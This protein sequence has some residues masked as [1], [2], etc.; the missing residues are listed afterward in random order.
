MGDLLSSDYVERHFDEDGRPAQTEVREA[1][2]YFEG[3]FSGTSACPRVL[4]AE[5]LDTLDTPETRNTPDTPETFSTLDT[6]DAPDTL[7]TAV[8]LNNFFYF[9]YAF[10]VII[11]VVSGHLGTL[12]SFC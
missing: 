4:M 11:A 12:Q 1:H 3:S 2:V 5:E 10:K 7:D 8:L 9:S 6:L